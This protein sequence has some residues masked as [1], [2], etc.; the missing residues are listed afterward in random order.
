VRDLP[1][2]DVGGPFVGLQRADGLARRQRGRRWRW[3]LEDPRLAQA[4]HEQDKGDGHD[5]A[6]DERV[7]PPAAAPAGAAPAGRAL[8]FF[9]AIA[10]RRH[11]HCTSRIPT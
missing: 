2:R 10:P 6:D 4:E 9:A 5:A 3:R 8:L 1:D 7:H 11:G